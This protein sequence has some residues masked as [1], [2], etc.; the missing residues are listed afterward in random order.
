M[1]NRRRY[2]NEDPGPNP[3]P[4]NY[5]LVETKEG[6]YYR[7]KRGR[8][9]RA[10]LNATLQQSSDSIK[11]CSPVAS[12]MAAAL[13]KDLR[14]LD[15]GRMI[16]R[17][18]AL[19]RKALHKNGK[20]DYSFFVDY[21]FQPDHPIDGLLRV[22]YRCQEKKGNIELQIQLIPEAVKKHNPLV[23]EYYFDLVLLYGDP[24][25]NDGLRVETITSPNYPYALS[26]ETTCKL[27]ITLPQREQPWMLML[28]VSSLEGKELAC[29]PKHYGMKVVK[30]GN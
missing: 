16:A 8:V 29:H 6:R 3:D 2:K 11:V 10:V 24:S 9:K 5:M 20:P 23:S 25:A 19:L 26:K 22:P 14:G 15:T 17:F 27:S 18:T 4:E 28:K 7:R 21:D 13:R 12:K 1:A 30:V